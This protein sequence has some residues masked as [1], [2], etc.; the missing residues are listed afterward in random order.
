MASMERS[1]VVRA[2]AKLNLALSV[3]APCAT[4]A[5]PATMMHP[6]SSWMVTVNLYDELHLERVAETHASLFATVWH[7]DALRRTEIDWDLSKDLVHRAHDRLE[8]FVGKALPVKSRLE[9]RI[10]VGGGLGG[11]S[12]DAAAMLR[13]LNEL[14][15][16]NVPTVE[17]ERIAAELG[18][19]IPFLVRG[20]SALVSGFGE[21]IEALRESPS[22]DAVLFFPDVQCPT[23]AVYGAFDRLAPLATL[24]EMRVRDLAAKSRL[25]ARDPFNDLTEAAKAIA[26]AM[27]DDIEELCDLSDLP[28]HVCG[29]GSSLFVVCSD[30]AH[31]VALAETATAKLAMPAVAISTTGG[32]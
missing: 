17:L 25:N 19:D 26:P 9:K 1:L 14:F 21:R 15:Q 22:L 10:P 31:A 30:P 2:P 5:S 13:A 28:V 24:N 32:G 4:S 7:A 27:A 12:S 20:G 3:G 11:G 23:G 6:L 29:S 8:Q 16:L 18:S